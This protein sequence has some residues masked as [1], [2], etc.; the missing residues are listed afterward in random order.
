MRYASGVTHTHCGKSI[1]K[2]D[3]EE[4]LELANR[5]DHEMVA[6]PRNKDGKVFH[7]GDTVNVGDGEDVY[8]SKIEFTL[9][10][11]GNKLQQLS[12]QEI[13]KFVPLYLYL[14]RLAHYFFDQ[15]RK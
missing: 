13:P 6:L 3:C 9:D 14:F 5:I 8:V 7:V 2:D 12:S 11:S 10:S 15:I 1:D 4:L